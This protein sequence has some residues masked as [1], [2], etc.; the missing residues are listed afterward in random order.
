MVEA[1]GCYH[2]PLLDA[3][4]AVSM[5]CL[6]YNPLLTKQQMKATVRG[7]KTDRSDAFLVAR[8]GWSGGGRLHVPEPYRLTKHYARSC[9]K[10][11]IL[12]SSFRQY[13]NHFTELLDGELTSDVQEVLAGIQTAIK[14]ARAQIYKDLAASANGEAFRLL[15]TIPGIGLYTASSIVGEIQDMSRFTTTK[16]LIA[17]A[18][19][20]PK[21]RQSGH[22][23]NST[24]KLT[25]RG[26]SYLRR[27]IFIAANVS[28][29][30]D[31]QFRALYDKKRTEG[32]KHTA[33]NCAVARKLL[34]VIRSVWLSGKGYQLPED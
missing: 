23:L 32:K 1:T 18:G 4:Q 13:K 22:S 29:Q 12:S 25:K 9:Q 7:K 31:P 21:I 6:V 20:D 5:A 34:R 33:A 14:E 2:Y 26:S 24:G 16:A 19:L 27:S 10:L 11:S 28:R 17:F 3:A 8:V 15:Q 30:F